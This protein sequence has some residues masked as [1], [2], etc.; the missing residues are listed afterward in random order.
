MSLHLFEAFGVELEYMLVDA[1][2]LDVVPAVDRIMHARAGEFAG[3][4]EAGDG[5]S[6]SNE[7]A[8]HVIE[9]KTTDPT[10]DLAGCAARFAKNIATINTLA[11]SLGRGQSRLM[12]GGMHPWMDPVTQTSLWPHEYSEVYAN[13]HRLFNCYRH[14]WA[15]LQSVHLNL[16]FDGD[17]EFGRLHAAVRM[18]L[19]LLPALCASSPIMDGKLTGIACNRLEVYR[20]NQAAVPSLAGRVIPEPVFNQA[21]YQRVIMN[22]IAR[23]V[24]RLDSS[25]LMKPQ[26]M[27]SRGAIARFDRG[28]IEI[29]VMD[30]QECPAADLAIVRGVV[31]VLQWLVSEGACS[32][33][34]QQSFQI[35]PLVEVLNATIRE[36]GR[37]ELRNA[38]YLRAMGFSGKGSCRADELWAAMLAHAGVPFRTDPALA[39]LA[40]ILRRGTL[41][42]RISQS[43]GGPPR[44]LG[45]DEMATVYA[46]LCE[47]LATNRVYGE[48]KA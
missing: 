38:D 48:A 42:Q 30:I 23:D 36:G 17:E 11:S 27:N 39:P 29:R 34:E 3:E 35:D 2:M 20:V 12:P 19:P 16:P 5:I 18:I 1:A 14:G 25:G 10:A 33:A 15:N 9:L 37:A 28:S 31:G 24:A 46:K 6:W 22:P 26:W 40:F 44:T 43:I 8:A 47:C 4:I 41:A 13:F 21:D 45:R 7:L 32:L